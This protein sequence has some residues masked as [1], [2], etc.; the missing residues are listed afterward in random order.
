MSLHQILVH[1]T[2]GAS[3]A[4]SAVMAYLVY[5][6]GI[7]L[8][9]AY[10][11]LA[12]LRPLIAPN[13]H[14][15]FELAKFEVSNWSCLPLSLSSNSGARWKLFQF[16]DLSSLFCICSAS[17]ATDARCFST[18]TGASTSLMSSAPKGSPPGVSWAS[19]APPCCYTA[20]SRTKRTY[21]ND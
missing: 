4:P 10:N 5:A 15:L 3:R 18:E 1:C 14:F 11:Y 2:I 7:P 21:S 19:T 16:C 17:W 20:P 13:Q 12:V 8:V 6:K 9:D